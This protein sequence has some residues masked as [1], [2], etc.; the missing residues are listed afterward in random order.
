LTQHH[1]AALP[2]LVVW[3]RTAAYFRIRVSQNGVPIAAARE[4]SGLQFEGLVSEVA[5]LGDALLS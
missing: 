5:D 4:S 2:S 3:T 1:Q